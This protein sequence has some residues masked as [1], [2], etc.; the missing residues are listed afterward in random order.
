[1]I[2]TL[3]VHDLYSKVQNFTYVCTNNQTCLRACVQHVRCDIH[4]YRDRPSTCSRFKST[5]MGL[6]LFTTSLGSRAPGGSGAECQTQ[7]AW[8]IYKLD[9]LIY[10]FWVNYSR[11]P[12]ETRRSLAEPLRDELWRRCIASMLDDLTPKSAAVTPLTAEMCRKTT[13]T[14]QRFRRISRKQSRMT[15]EA[16]KTTITGYSRG[17]VSYL[18]TAITGYRLFERCLWSDDHSILL[19]LTL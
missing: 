15:A 19:P 8:L 6:A 5:W 4:A 17:F 14:G 11:T 10:P 16:L 13:I 1:M 7:A 3:R 9:N 18:K 12:P 2:R